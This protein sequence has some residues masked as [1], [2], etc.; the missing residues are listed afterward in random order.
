ML[1]ASLPQ[2]NALG[3]EE[4]LIFEG[5]VKTIGSKDFCLAPHTLQG[6]FSSQ[7][8]STE[9]ACSQRS[10]SSAVKAAGKWLSMSS[11]PTTF[12]ST[13]TGSTISDFVSTE[14]AR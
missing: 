13:K 11:S 8:P 14:Q 1:C 10:R 6:C 9:A 7:R 5:L 2:H 12:L 3:S 4:R